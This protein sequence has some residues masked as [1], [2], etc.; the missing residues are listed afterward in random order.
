MKMSNWK[1]YV[2]SRNDDDKVFIQQDL[3][4]NE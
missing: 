1:D 3:E 4:N 2:E